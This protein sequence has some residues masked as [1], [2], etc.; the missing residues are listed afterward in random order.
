VTGS[1]AYLLGGSPAGGDTKTTGVQVGALAAD[2]APQAWS[3]AS[4][5]PAGIT[6]PAA[7]SA[8]GF[9]YVVGGQFADPP[10][11]QVLVAPIAADHSLGPW[12]TTTPLPL[13][14]TQLTAT[15]HGGWLYAI[16]GRD[17]LD[18]D[19]T[20][21]Y[22]PINVDGTLGAWQTT[23]SLPEARGGLALV[24]VGSRLY[25]IGGRN[26]S[27]HLNDVVMSSFNIDGTL[28]PWVQVGTFATGREVPQ[29]VVDSGFLYILGGIT[30]V[31]G[32]GKLDDVQV[33]RVMDNGSLGPFVATTPLP[34]PRDSFGVYAV[35]SEIYIV[36]GIGA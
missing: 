10:I 26:S 1:S 16:G 33:A 2:G 3:V 8:N 13:P 27:G 7:A 17:A 14:R 18:A 36:G 22:A 29:A 4:E 20:V 34:S 6:Y 5:L 35:A 32:G 31:N 11:D 23:T 19:D 24:T 28:A 15:I 25:A 12:A 9:V 30:V 21:F